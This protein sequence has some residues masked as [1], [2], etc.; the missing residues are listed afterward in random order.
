MQ[1]DEY[2]YYGKTRKEREKERE[3][4]G[5]ERIEREADRC[6]ESLIRKEESKRK[7]SERTKNNEEQRLAGLRAKRDKDGLN[8]ACAWHGCIFGFPPL[9][10]AAASRLYPRA[11]A[12]LSH[13]ADS[14]A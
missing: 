11:A 6:V 2:K 3:S 7:A 4:S 5:R 14:Q 8:A 9:A 13:R 12:P 1:S 10:V